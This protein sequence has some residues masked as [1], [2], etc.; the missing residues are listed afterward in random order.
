M[1]QDVLQGRRALVLYRYISWFLTSTFYL[2]AEPDSPLLFKVGV[3]ATLLV[4]GRI[5]VHLYEHSSGTALNTL[6]LITVETAGIA[7]LLV[8]TGGLDSPFMWY[9]LNPIFMA[10]TMLPGPYCWGVLTV[11]L[12]AASAGSAYVYGQ[13]VVTAWREN[14]WL[15][16]VFLLLTA[17]GQVF[18]RLVRHLSQAYEDL[19]GAHRSTERSLEHI[20]ALYQALESFSS[21]DDPR[22]LAGLLAHYARKLTASRAAVCY[23]T[24]DDGSTQLEASDPDGFLSDIVQ[25]QDTLDKIW[26]Q[27]EEGK[28][29]VYCLLLDQKELTGQ[30]VYVPVQSPS[31]RFGFLGYLTTPSDTPPLGNGRRAL[32]FLA[33]LGAIVLERRKAEDLAARLLVAEEQNRIA[34]EIHDGVAQHLFSIVFALH[35]LAQK[36]AGLQDEEVQRQLT[37]VKK[38]ANQAARELRASIYR[39]SPRRRGEQVFVAGVSSYLK[40]L[41]QL[42]GIKVDFQVEGSEE[43]VSPA[44]RKALYRIIRE[45]TSNA[46]R[47]GK[48]SSIKVVLKMAPG[49]VMLEVVDDGNGFD[50]QQKGSGLGLSNMRSLMASFRG[51]FT[52]TS[53][54]GKGVR[55]TCMVPAG[56]CQSPV[57][58]N[59]GGAEIESCGR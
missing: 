16:L 26:K 41:A 23:L 22:C 40:G 8:P 2:I 31:T 52:V 49:K 10:A 37:L 43:A 17:A 54:P 30:L 44:L 7:L 45:A 58:A 15:L 27:V 12:A 48:C 57:D 4:A 5:A 36:D 9:A 19:A 39:I 56:D 32:V 28:E 25:K 13:V 35:A 29:N 18:T 11:F 47:H 20:A 34:N 51:S 59:T 3:V 14:S 24:Q 38:A 1:P 53:K 55:V 42:N 6:G 50:V 21:R 46:I 33:E